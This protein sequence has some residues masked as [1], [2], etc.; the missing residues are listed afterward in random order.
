[1]RRLSRRAKDRICAHQFAECGYC[2]ARL[3]D[4]F[5]VDHMDEDCTNDAEENTVATCGTCHSIKTM[6]YRKQRTDQLQGML[7][8]VHERREVWRAQWA[9]EAS[10]PW[11]R[12]PDWL[13]SRVDIL[14]VR[15]HAVRYL[16][17]QSVL[18]LEQF[19]YTGSR[20]R[21]PRQAS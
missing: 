17:S 12:M 1:M 6:H 4:A 15:M 18:D 3:C 7:K 19:R 16:P 10:D 20:S 9:D 2:G 11:E 14:H 21:T 13:K 8:S 5:Q